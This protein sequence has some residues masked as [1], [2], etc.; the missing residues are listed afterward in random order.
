MHSVTRFALVCCLAPA[1]ATSFARAGIVSISGQMELLSPAPPSVYSGMLESNEFIRVYSERSNVTLS[2]ALTVN[3]VH[4]GVTTTYQPQPPAGG[5]NPGT[6][7]AGT[8]VNTY[9]A[10]FD[11]IG[12][13]MP[14]TVSLTGSLTLSEDILGLM[15]FKDGLNV[16]DLAFGAPGTIYGADPLHPNRGLEANGGNGPPDTITLSGDFHTLTIDLVFAG[17][18]IDEIRVFAT[19]EPHS[20]AIALLGGLLFL[21]RERCQLDRRG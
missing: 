13:D 5:V 18:G 16:T 1:L 9:F 12:E 4:P 10:H 19:P 6:L 21:R 8:V 2:S 17:T 15:V 7:A 20:L 11:P 14:G 3:V